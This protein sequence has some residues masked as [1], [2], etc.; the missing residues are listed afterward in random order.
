VSAGHV[1]RHLVELIIKQVKGHGLV[2]SYDPER[3]YSQG[4][5][6]TGAMKAL[7]MT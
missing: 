4:D 3:H 5:P 7:G 2:A 6:L 1:T